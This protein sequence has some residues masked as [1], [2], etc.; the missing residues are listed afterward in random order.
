MLI[1]KN[2]HG[3]VV[4]STV[5]GIGG[6][7]IGV[8]IIFIIVQ[9]LT[10]ADLFS[11]VNLSDDYVNETTIIMNETGVAIGNSTQTSCTLSAIIATNVTDGE[12]IDAANYTTSACTLLYTGAASDYNDTTWNVTSTS[13]YTV[14]SDEETASTDMST[15][16]SGGVDN[17][18][19]KI[20]TI[21]LIV[22]VVF[23]FGAL[24]LLIRNANLM[25]VGGGSS[26]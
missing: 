20:P 5:M 15:N 1:P 3:G 26:L 21:L 4:T 18:S 19:E 11:D 6:L 14:L 10:G 22:A 12:T 13:S 24:V 17:I 16:F 8:I 23:L 2:K 7:L 25:G 9:T